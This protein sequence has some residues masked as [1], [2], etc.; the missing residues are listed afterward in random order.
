MTE[1]KMA[2]TQ[3]NISPATRIVTI[4]VAV[5]ATSGLVNTVSAQQSAGVTVDVDS[6]LDLKS[7]DEQL[8]CY[9]AR[10]NEVLQAQEAA[11]NVSAPPASAAPARPA[12]VS[13]PAEAADEDQIEFVASI[14]ALR[15]ILPNQFEISLDNGQVWRQSR[16]K[17][18][19]LYL[20]AEV[21]LRPGR[22]GP[23]YRLTDPK[24][25]NFVQV[26]RVK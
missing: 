2:E 25:G 14:T 4:A 11:G 8:A 6:C 19:N 7:R 20:G 9:E 10:V 3:N 17:R 5:L 26:K 16:P 1:T 24:V 21:T 22:W 18:Y 15:E 13:A 12:A 23:S